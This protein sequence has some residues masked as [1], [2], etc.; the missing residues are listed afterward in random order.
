M[1]AAADELVREAGL[2][3][4]RPR[5]ARRRHRAG[6][7]HL[8]PDRARHR[9]R[10]RRSRSASRPPASRRCMRSP[11]ATPVIDAR[12]GEVFT[13]RPVGRPARG[14]RRRGH[15]GSSAT[16]PS[17]TASVFEAAGAEI[18]PDDDPAHLPAARLLVARAGAFG[19]AEAVE[20]ALRPRPRRGAEPMTARRD[21]DPPA[22]ALRP[23][24]HRGDR[25]ARLPRR[26]GRGRCSPPSSRSRRSICLGALEG[27]AAGRLRRSTR[28]TSTPGT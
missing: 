12:R 27:D 10:A 24:R 15:A 13:D 1:L 19:P 25:A 26:R 22:R 9:A 5:R 28:A 8:D 21:R 6:Q 7:L 4:R 2:E 18:P 20:P 14:A 16:A 11:A 3:P 23:R 17:A